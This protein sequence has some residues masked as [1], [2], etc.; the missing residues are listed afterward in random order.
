VPATPVRPKRSLGQNFLHDQNISRKIVN[1]IAPDPSDVIVEV[2]PGTGAL[3]RHLA[4]RARELIV[5]EIDERVIR[6]LSELTAGLGVRVTHGDF[7]NTDLAAIAAE[8]GTRVRIVGNVPYHI[9]SPILFHIL[10]FRSS[11]RDVTIMVQREVARRIVASPGTKEY[12]ILSVFCQLFGNP[13]IMFDVSPNAFTPKPKVTSSVIRYEILTAPRYPV[14]DESFFRMVIRGVFGKRRKTL[15]NSLSYLF[16][17]GLPPGI[18]EADLQRRPED[19]SIGDL[20]DLTN[21]LHEQSPHV[22]AP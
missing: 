4:G 22:I 20:V 17:D 15:R 16:E 12:G 11:V 9:T 8:T 3:T 1:A 13:K 10:D 18:P 14:A 21:T 7:L 5:V 6:Y 19:L 2:G